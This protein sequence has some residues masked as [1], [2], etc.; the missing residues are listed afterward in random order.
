MQQSGFFPPFTLAPVCQKCLPGNEILMQCCDLSE[1]VLGF[2]GNCGHKIPLLEFFGEEQKLWLPRVSLRKQLACLWFFARGDS[3]E[4]TLAATDV[5]WDSAQKLYVDFVDVVA[6]HQE[7]AN[8][9][10]QVGGPGLEVEADEVAF[11]CKAETDL[12]G[13]LKLWWLR[14]FGMARRGSSKMFLAK[15][16]DRPVKGQGQGGGGALSKE[17][18]KDVLQA[19]SMS[20]R[21]L[22]ESILHTDSAKAYKQVG[23]LAWPQ[24]GILHAAFETQEPFLAHGWC[25][26]VVTHKKKVGQK[27]QFVAE[28]TVK[29]RNGTT[30]RVLAGTEKVD[31]YWASLRRSVG[32]TSVNTGKR[33]GDQKRRTWLHKLVR[34]HQ[35]R[36]WHLGEDLFNK[37][38]Q[39]HSQRRVAEA[40]PDYF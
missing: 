35:W 19:E 26:T 33:T 25:H 8:N 4:K 10:L 1:N 17:E 5:A 38:G 15:L 34:V 30:K 7:D 16:P 12:D 20:P 3:V 11:R 31:G 40:A 39:V 32:K 37:L 14:Y 18:L 13:E 22:P 36:W 28:R 27:I 21:L 29:M 9:K 23:P 6:A 2:K 24:A